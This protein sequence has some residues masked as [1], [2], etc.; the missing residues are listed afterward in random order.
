MKFSLV[1][2]YFDK[3]EQV[4]KRLEMTSLLAELL[5]QAN[6]QESALI[7]YLSLGLLHP[8]YIGTQFNIARKLMQHIIAQFLSVDASEIK[9]AVMNLGDEGT[10]IAQQ[11]WSQEGELTLQQVY[12]ALS[13]LE[14]VSGIGSQEKKADL[15]QQLLRSMTP[16]QAKYV[17]RI[18]LGRLRLGF[19]DMTILDA[20]S[21]M[22]TGDK[23]LRK[24]L[25]RAYNVCA[26]IGLIARR[27][28]DGD[29]QAIN[30]THISVGIPIRPA[31]AERMNT[32]QNII[33]K[34]GP[35]IAQPKLDGFRLQIHIDNR[36]G[37]HEVHFFSRNLQDMSHMFPD[38]KKLCGDLQVSTLVCEG[39]AICYDANTGNYLPF[40]ETI[41][42]KRKHNVEQAAQDLP[43]KVVLF[44]VLYLDEQEL[45][46]ATHKQRRQA[47]LEL[48][49]DQS[50]EHIHVI[51]ERK[52][53]TAQELSDYF[54]ANIAA[55]LE[56]LVVKREDA[57][58]QPGKR[59]F[60]WIKLKRQE[61]GHLDDTI[62]CVILGYYAGRGKRAKFGIGALLV[63]LYNSA[64]DRFE[65]VAKIGT[66][67]KDNEW[68][69]IK[70][71]C[72]NFKVIEQ[73]HNVI[74]AKELRP[75]VWVT[76]EI[77]TIIRAD[78]ITMSPMHSA[79]K[80][81]EQLGYALRFPR[82]MGSRDD[83]SAT[84]ATTVDEI[85]VMYQQQFGRN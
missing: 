60:N 3:I 84:D 53:S 70:K 63:G 34:L 59:N 30:D 57:Q 72:D 68:I 43:L 67:L 79:G 26:D 8:P 25:E 22:Q 39:E 55:G 24:D 74:C 49:R 50:D 32:A 5:Q 81:N 47:L 77:V 17:V 38:V 10:F 40:Q 44:D 2:Q 31:A 14:K 9:D 41:K 48:M 78:E 19:S 46:T 71:V 15:L 66:G 82:F 58:Y 54:V 51:E 56:G 36:D 1:A 75:D 80:T 18:V 69:A 73:P 52:V 21:W 11:S 29:M 28:K 45:L 6:A 61:E 13:Q 4:Q 37:K 27:L 42:R 64:H 23:S 83:K 35:C 7:S 76:P 20:L 16:Q 65:T 62:D 12:D 85:K 33:D